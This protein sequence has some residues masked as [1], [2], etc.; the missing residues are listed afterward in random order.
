MGRPAL[1]QKQQMVA[2]RVPAEL[3]ADFFGVC[4]TTDRSASQ[5]LRDFMRLVVAQHHAK[6]APVWA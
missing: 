5:L 1:A 2:I 3:H 4:K 6:L